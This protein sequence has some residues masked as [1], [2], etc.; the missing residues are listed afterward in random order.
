MMFAGPM[1]AQRA[2]YRWVDAAM[3]AGT[4]VRPDL[5]DLTDTRNIKIMFGSEQSA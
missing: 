2:V 4:P 5:S 1:Q 3:F